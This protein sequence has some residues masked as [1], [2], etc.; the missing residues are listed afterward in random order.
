[1]QLDDYQL[2]NIRMLSPGGV[3]SRED[4]AEIF[5]NRDIIMRTIRGFGFTGKVTGYKFGPRVTRYEIVLADADHVYMIAE[6]VE[7]KLAGVFG[8]RG[9]RVVRLDPENAVIGVEIA[10]TKG[11]AVFLRSVVESEAW[12][13]GDAEIPI[14]L[15]RDVAGQP[16]VIDI[17]TA[18][19]I[20]IS[21]STGSGKSACIDSLILSLLLKFEPDELKFIL[22]DP[23]IVE[24]DEYREL[25]H[26][27]APII[28]DETK[29]VGALRWTVGEIESRRRLMECANT[30]DIGEYN[31]CCARGDK[32]PVIVV[33]VDEL[34]DFMVN[35][36][37]MRSSVE[38]SIAYIAQR[39]RSAGVH[40]VVVTS[41]SNII[42]DIIR[43]HLP[44][45]LC[46][47][48]RSQ[49]DSCAVLDVPGA[50]KLLGT[51]DMLMK[52]PANATI[53]RV[54][55][56]YVPY[57]DIHHIVRFVCR[58]AKA[59][60]DHDLAEA[61]RSFNF[62]PRRN[63]TMKSD[64][65]AFPSVNLLSVA[66]IEE[67]ESTAEI[68]RKRDVIMQTLCEFDIAGEVTDYTV[69]PRVTRFEI[70]ILPSVE[71]KEIEDIVDNIA[72]NLGVSAI[73]FV[74]FDHRR[75]TVGLEVENTRS[76]RK[77]IWGGSILTGKKW[78]EFPGALPLL[79]G[80]TWDDAPVIGRLTTA[81]HILIS[82]ATG[83]G[84]SVMMHA[85]IAGL[86]FKY[87]PEALKFI[88][89][90]LKVIEFEIYEKIPHL[91]APIIHDETKAGGALRWAVG[92]I[93]RRF[94]LMRAAGVRN[95]RE[96]ND[97]CNEEAKLPYIVIV[98]DD[99]A[100]LMMTDH[101]SSARKP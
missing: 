31:R 19:H 47:Q 83:T 46:F 48:V 51:G 82:G 26:L 56:A 5:A 64:N 20:L 87:R 95:I 85:I 99:V 62:A 79:I 44:T 29:A 42:T 2:P 69:G 18:P 57:D 7:E 67:P 38:E 92:E 81:P 4:G 35:D 97:F 11:E 41:R 33:V 94:G 22:I 60:F 40:I 21:G 13:H 55:G 37:S 34:S 36:P 68:L 17:D 43:I 15:G 32:L 75:H 12:R 54:Q 65:Y 78:Q 27:L 96:Y 59:K 30:N 66:P 90:D 91:L 52:S 1:M 10:N 61:I 49:E 93:E 23:K 39:G 89:I 53:K 80:E 16:V 76:R 63:E 58:Q 3:S 25:P 88:L 28:H 6:R 72:M 73:R 45:R 101:P 71:P 9:V 24:L 100:D 14:A 74:P 86:L 84:K 8:A 77:S 98:V 70:T 50:E